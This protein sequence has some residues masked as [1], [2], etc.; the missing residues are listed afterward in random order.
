MICDF[1]KRDDG[2]NL[3]NIHGSKEQ[4]AKAIKQIKEIGVEI[5]DNYVIE[6]AAPHINSMYSDYVAIVYV[7]IPEEE[8]DE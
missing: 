5:K 2:Y 1:G 7:W 3:F 6:R 8:E 4:V